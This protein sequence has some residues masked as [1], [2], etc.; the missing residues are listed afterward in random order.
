MLF[1]SPF[2]LFAFLP[3]FL[4]VYF[5]FPTLRIRNLVVLLFSAFFLAW[6]DLIFLFYV[7]IGTLIDYLVIKYVFCNEKYNNYSKKLW[8]IAAIAINVGALIFF[9]YANFLFDQINPLFELFAFDKPSWYGVALPLGISFVAF[10]KISFLMDLYKGRIN[11]PKS[12]INALIYILLFPQLIA[13]PIVRYQDIGYQIENRIIKANNF[14]SGFFCF[15]YGLAKKT[16]IA[17]PAGVIADYVFNLQPQAL[18][19]GYAWLGIL[20]F[21]MQIYFDFSGYSNMAIGLARM[22]GFNFPENFNQP[23]TARNITDFWSR[24]HITLS[25]WMGLYLYIPLGGNRVRKSRMY[26]NLW[27]VFL[28]SGFWHGSAWT[29]I[30]WGAY[31]GFFLTLEKWMNI[32]GISF[33]IPIFFKRLT[34][35]LVILNSWV[36]FRADSLPYAIKFFERMYDFSSEPISALEPFSLAFHPHD[37]SMLLIGL[38][39]SIIKIPKFILKFKELEYPI[40]RDIIYFVGGIILLIISSAYIFSFGISSFLYFR[41]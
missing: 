5:L 23:Y 29:F 18:S 27:I 10:H 30:A 7:F 20:A 12:L 8:L 9:K 34:T 15:S 39:F 37:V 4:L 21:T 33:K 28:V 22:I 6:G 2:F 1:N 26:I 24:W 31:F 38:L 3:T 25:K 11:P 32:N 41:F 36:L 17:D 14:L 40:F 35:F 13:G 16:V 19:V